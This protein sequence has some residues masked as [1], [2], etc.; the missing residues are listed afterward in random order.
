MEILM[1][2]VAVFAFGLFIWVRDL[3]IG[4]ED[5]RWLPLALLMIVLVPCTI[6]YSAVNMMLMADAVRIPMRFVDGVRVSAY[7]QV[8]E[9]LPLPGGAIV[10][11][12]ALVNA[13]ADIRRSGGL[14][15][16]FSLL[17][18][19]CAAGVGGMATARVGWAALVAA[20]AGAG[21]VSLVFVWIGR[22]FGYSVALWAVGLR[23]LGVGLLALRIIYACAVIDFAIGFDRAIAF[24]SAAIFGSAAAIVPAGLGVSESLSA[25]LSV[26]L[27]VPPAVGFLAAAISRLAGFSVDMLVALVFYLASARSAGKVRHG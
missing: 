3:G 5:I 13:G 17:W 18:I 9:I 14:V 23:V 16:S 19:G 22:N 12:A 24:A 27:S 6:A 25:L 21:L 2:A 11:T 7:A 20:C 10:R 1:L 15:L 4:I 8:A 26:P